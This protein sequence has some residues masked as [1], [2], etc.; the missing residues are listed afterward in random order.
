MNSRRSLPSPGLRC[1]LLRFGA[2]HECP[3]LASRR[4][5]NSADEPLPPPRSSA[6]DLRERSLRYASTYS[7]RAARKKLRPK[8]HPKNQSQMEPNDQRDLTVMHRGGCFAFLALQKKSTCCYVYAPVFNQ[9]V[10]E[11]F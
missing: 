5:R 7:Q 10:G 1:L 8:R 6:L 4:R 9:A 2:L 3:L 11:F